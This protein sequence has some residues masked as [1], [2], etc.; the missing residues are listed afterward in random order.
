MNRFQ[1]LAGKQSQAMNMKNRERKDLQTNLL[2][3]APALIAC[4]AVLG[5]IGCSGSATS[6]GG[7]LTSGVSTTYT[8]GG[9]LAGLGVG[10][11]VSLQDK[12]GGALTL[13]AN[14]AFSFPT[15]LDTG[16]AYAV[17]VQSHT[18][19]IACSVS[20]G[21]GTV[22]P[23][24][25]TGI[26][27]SC[28]AGT[29]RILYSFGASATD[30][31]VPNGPLVVDSSGN[32]YG[33]T[34]DGG[35]NGLYDGTV[36]K[37][38]AAGTETTLYS[39]GASATDGQVPIGGLVI[40]AAGNL[41]GTTE[42]GGVNGD[43]TVFKI[44]T[45]GEETILHSFG[46]GFTDGGV[47]SAGLIMDSAGDLYGMTDLGGANGGGTVFKIDA[48]GK[49]TILYSFA[50][51]SSDGVHP[52]GGLIMDGAGNLYG[53]T[54]A[55]GF[56]YGTVFKLNSSGTET[57]LYA[58]GASLDGEYPEGGLALDSAGNLYGTTAYAQESSGTVFEIGADGTATLLYAFGTTVNDESDGATPDASL[59]VD[60]AGNLYG[61]T[62]GGGT[63]NERLG[64]YGT[65]YRIEKIGSSITETVLYSFGAS[66]TDGT[67]PN[68][69]IVDS[70]GNLYGTTVNGGANGKGTI[71]AID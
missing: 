32:V 44:D 36:F 2:G 61:T 14:G 52:S 55:G 13:S 47:P 60:S 57:V 48:A 10:Q 26:S 28:S 23:A 42:Y 18:P 17:T 16:S 11:S 45:A 39:F 41:Y 3:N 71:F 65:V 5:S 12:G 37:I 8:V 46:I 15:S 6:S 29:E 43:G 9:T 66:A 53:T 63:N 56:G 68:S 1:W 27:V 4:V 22:G 34:V 49:E 69:L 7:G 24:N 38:S 67:G 40:D 51:N 64:G 20:S 25:V 35:V 58:I 19:G 30:G 54:R 21:S 50:A 59:V 31:V 33:T 70:A 62:I